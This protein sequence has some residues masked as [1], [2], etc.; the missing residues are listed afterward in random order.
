MSIFFSYHFPDIFFDSNSLN[1]ALNADFKSS[2]GPQGSAG[3]SSSLMDFE[4]GIL[5]DLFPGETP[6]VDDV[7]VSPQTRT[8][9]PPPSRTA[10][11]KMLFSGSQNEK[12]T[13]DLESHEVDDAVDAVVDLLSKNDEKL[14]S[15]ESKSV[16]EEQGYSV[17]MDVM[18][19]I[20]KNF[21]QLQRHFD[22]VTEEKADKKEIPEVPEEPVQPRYLRIKSIHTLKTSDEEEIPLPAPPSGTVARLEIHTDKLNNRTTFKVMPPYS[23]TC[24]NS[25]SVNTSDINRATQMLKPVH[26]EKFPFLRDILMLSKQ[27][28]KPVPKPGRVLRNSNGVEEQEL[29][30]ELRGYG[31]VYEG[32]SRSPLG[33][34]LGWECPEV[35]CEKV[36]EKRSKL[37][38]HIF[39]HRNVRPFKCPED[40]KWSFQTKNKLERHLKSV[41]SKE[42][43]FTCHIEECRGKNVTFS[44]PYNLNNHLKRH[45]RPLVKCK[46]LGCG[47]EFKTEKE[48]NRHMK[49]ANHEDILGP[50]SCEEC[51]MRFFSPTD[52]IKHTQMHMNSK[53]RLVCQFENCGKE[54][55][56]NSS[57]LSHV[58][59]HTGEKPFQC[60]VEGCGW[61][62]RT[63]SKLRRHE[64]SHFDQRQSV[65]GVCNKAYRRPEHLKEHMNAVHND[66]RFV[67][68]F[69]DCSVKFTARSSL[70]IHMKKH[71][72]GD[73][74]HLRCVIESCNLK[75]SDSNILSNHVTQNHGKEMAGVNL[76]PDPPAAAEEAGDEDAAA[77]AEL[78]FIALLSSVGDDIE[79]KQEEISEYPFPE[80]QGELITVDASAITPIK[81]DAED[82]SFTVIT[83]KA[84]V[85]KKK[86]LVTEE[87]P[88]PEKRVSLLKPR[89]TSIPLTPAVKKTPEKTEKQRMRPS[90]LRRRSK[91]QELNLE[92]TIN[93]Q[94]LA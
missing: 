79:D 77:A 26:L 69:A 64:R 59:V 89:P 93:L 75:F 73:K 49:S 40:C 48:L 20:H 76:Q 41:H 71:E 9:S 47:V 1:S 74:G 94:D 84:K 90:I 92:T 63:S 34:R 36:Y 3:P 91:P 53:E 4:K 80:A 87:I 6:V 38:L 8:P 83:K 43:L 81:R 7:V 28:S 65:C 22:K 58:R 78:D 10:G 85:K 54:F 23:T 12:R 45:N 72:S 46:S 14:A 32:L 15:P 2:S 51:D 55:S 82:I 67:C 18:R 16:E 21:E 56:K 24:T 30:D 42:K 88:G 52:L 70:Y 62:F 60:E 39:S 5:D 50:H 35:N 29:L 19:T 66:V 44:T 57:L 86:C 17:P 13:E 27:K 25:L 37:K 33:G 61:A 31:I 11:D 68:P